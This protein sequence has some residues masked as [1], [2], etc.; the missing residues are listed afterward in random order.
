MEERYPEIFRLAQPLLN[1]R[2]NELHTRI[3]FSFALK[4]LDAEGGNPDVVLTAVLLHDIGWMSIPEELHL[5]AFGPTNPDMELQRVHEVEGSRL[6][7]EILEQVNYNPELIGEI[8]EIILGHDSRKEALSLND[9]IVKDA[10]RLWRYSAEGLE[11]DPVRFNI[12][13]A[14]H[15]EWL[16]RQID[17][18][19][20]TETAKKLAREE[21]QKGV[22]KYGL[23]PRE[24]LIS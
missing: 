8:A 17:R 3:A 6:A 16:K 21:H 11:I 1:T 5:K 15:V 10:D 9:A 18:W 23:P 12:D 13:P 20:Y 24:K 19:F 2:D 4:L 7:K 14:V 22:A